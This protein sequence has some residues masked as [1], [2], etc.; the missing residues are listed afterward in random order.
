M[1]RMRVCQSKDRGAKDG[2]GQLFSGC[3]GSCGICR[4]DGN[5]PLGNR[6]AENPVNPCRS[7]NRFFCCRGAVVRRG[8]EA[9]ARCDQAPL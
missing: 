6:L 1:I 7:C 3:L 4:I 5:R 2:S 8:R 9:A